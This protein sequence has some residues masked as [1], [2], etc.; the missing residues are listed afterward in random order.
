[1]KD[2]KVLRNGKVIEKENTKLATGDILKIENE[3]YTVVIKG[4]ISCDGNVG[5]NE[6]V[7]YRKYLLE[8]INYNKLEEK[9][10]DVNMDSKLDT[11]DLVEIRKLILK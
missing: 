2:F 5:L 3:E 7:S 1:M 10:A 4:D 11:K 6:V 9:A 8:Y